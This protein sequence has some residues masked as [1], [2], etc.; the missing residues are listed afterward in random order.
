[1]VGAVTKAH[2]LRGEVAVQVRSDNP[3]R[4]APGAIVLT[5]SGRTLTI[6][7]AQGAGGRLLV[8]FAEVPDRAAAERLRGE[9]LVVPRS[10]L[11]PLPA[12]EFWP[13]QLI[14][15]VVRTETGHELGSLTEV[16]AN[17]AHDLWVAVDDEGTETLIP[18]LADVVLNVDLEARRVV[19]RALP[20]LTVPDA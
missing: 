19:V 15:C 7:R 8:R 16:V 18:A 13:H 3:D 10:W 5:G 1:V 12:G 17:P 11:P 9:M 14:G 6:E 2:G 20:G 4:F